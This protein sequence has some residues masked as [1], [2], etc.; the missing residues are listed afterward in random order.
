[1]S[2]HS[3]DSPRTGITEDERLLTTVPSTERRA[4]VHTDPWRVLRIMGEFVE[5]LRHAVRRALRG[6]H[7]RLGADQAGRR[8]LRQG[9]GD[10]PP[11]RQAGVPHHHGRRA[12]ASWRPRIAG[13]RRATGSRSGAT[14]SCRSS[15][16]PTRIV[17]RSIN[18]RYFFV[19]KTMFVK[20]ST[21]FIVFPGGFGTLD[22]LFEALTLIQ[23]GKVKHFP[24]VLFGQ[25][26]LDGHGRLA[27]RTGSRGRARSTPKD[28]DLFHV[29]D[30]P[31]EAVALV[32][33]ARGAAAAHSRPSRKASDPMTVVAASCAGARIDPPAITGAETV[34]ELVDNAFLAY[35]AGRL[36]EGVPA[37]HRAHARARRDRR[38]E[39]HRRADAGGPRHE[40]DHPADRGGLRRLDRLDRRE[41]VPRHPLRPRPRDAPGHAVRRRRGAARAGRGAHLRHLLRLRRAARRPTP[42]SARCRR[43]PSSS[44]R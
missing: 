34:A 9:R 17:E 30:D 4:F 20:Y 28:L 18:F 29:T 25:R 42:S 43:G 13:R 7:L 38:D 15:R 27:A 26:L 6:H 24:V 22:E 3:S 44:A 1:M 5:G 36:R 16:A 40:H 31:A 41:P 39:P 37:V 10:R 8:V 14:S 32:I 35:N 11:A 21:A 19:R 33:K 23:T 2:Q 12:R